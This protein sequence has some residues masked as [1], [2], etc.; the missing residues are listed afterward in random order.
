M[1]QSNIDG[2][3]HSRL[4]GVLHTIAR[5]QTAP[6]PTRCPSSKTGISNPKMFTPE[7]QTF[8]ETVAI[9]NG[10]RRLSPKLDSR[11]AAAANDG[12]HCG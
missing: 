1:L 6:R 8:S 10:E 2:G 7:A 4:D 5:W 9:S 3:K 11:C 12:G